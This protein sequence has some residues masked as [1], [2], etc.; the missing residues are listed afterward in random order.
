MTVPFN[1]LEKWF[2]SDL[3][4]AELS[5][6]EGMFFQ[7][8]KEG[9][10][11][12]IDEVRHLL[13]GNGLGQNV[14]QAYDCNPMIVSGNN[15]TAQAQQWILNRFWDD[16]FM[17]L[18]VIENVDV[19]VQRFS[20]IDETPADNWM[21]LFRQGMLTFITENNLPQNSLAPLICHF[22]QLLGIS[23]LSVLYTARQCD[24]GQ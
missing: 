21:R 7:S 14:M 20:L 22:S 4:K 15:L 12:L 24:K 1:G 5:G 11:N 19:R 10:P 9:E 18:S 16:Q 8:R 13:I 23:F 3:N 2:K 17:Q 6:K